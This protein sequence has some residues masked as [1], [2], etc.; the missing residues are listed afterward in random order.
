MVY[1]G[2]VGFPSLFQDSKPY[3]NDQDNWVQTS[4]DNGW[5]PIYEEAK[6]RG[7]VYN[8]GKDKEAAIAFGEGSWKDQLPDEGVELTD[9]EVEEYKAGGY[10]VEEIE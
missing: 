7:E 5:G 8:F 2:W 3:A 9:E 10:I 6:R 4:E 1:V